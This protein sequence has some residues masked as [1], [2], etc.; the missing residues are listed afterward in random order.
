MAT[1][2]SEIFVATADFD[3]LKRRELALDD[4]SK[5]VRVVDVARTINNKRLLQSNMCL[6]DV[7]RFPL[8]F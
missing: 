2:D 5:E 6:A 1:C 3:V 8:F 7:K 4:S